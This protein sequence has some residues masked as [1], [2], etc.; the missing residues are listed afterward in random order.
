MEKRSTAVS[1]LNEGTSSPRLEGTLKNS[2]CP[3]GAKMPRHFQSLK[4]LKMQQSGNRIFALRLEKLPGWQFLQ[5]PLE[6]SKSSGQPAG[7]AQAAGKDVFCSRYNDRERPVDRKGRKV[8]L[9][10]Q[11]E[12]SSEGYERPAHQ[13]PVRWRRSAGPRLLDASATRSALRHDRG[14]SA[15][16]TVRA[17]QCLRMT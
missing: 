2:R 9:R 1:R 12:R 5:G 7:S 17:S 13:P 4:R 8:G 6:R 10:A 14:P 15:V 3:C 16:K 11:P